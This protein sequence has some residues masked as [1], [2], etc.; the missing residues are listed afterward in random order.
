MPPDKQLEERVL[1]DCNEYL[2]DNLPADDIS[3]MM[4]SENLLTPRE[5]EDYKAMKRSGKSIICL[6]EYL[7]ECLAKRKAGFLQVFCSMLRKIAAAEY[8]GDHIRD[9]YN[10]AILQG[11]KM[12]IS[13]I[14]YTEYIVHVLSSGFNP[15]TRDRLS[16]VSISDPDI[17]S[18]MSDLGLSQRTLLAIINNRLDDFWPIYLP[19]T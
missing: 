3:P 7:L 18:K 13:D 1:L 8:L 2:I 15:A 10:M 6:S 14:C 5:Y 12:K 11:G 17:R 16:K 9:A 19:A 4:M